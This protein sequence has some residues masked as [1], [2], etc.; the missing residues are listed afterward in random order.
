VE[1]PALTQFMLWISRNSQKLESFDSHFLFIAGFAYVRTTKPG[2]SRN[3]RHILKV[4][5]FGDLI[6]K[7]SG[8]SFQSYFWFF[9]C[10]GVPI[11]TALKFRDTAGNQIIANAIDAS[12]R[13]IQQGGMISLQKEQV[14]RLW[15]FR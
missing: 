3:N 8:G 10:S 1:L 6:Q 15:Q 2:R 14:F 4:P 12:R 5:L 7:I 11:L 13:D 9:D